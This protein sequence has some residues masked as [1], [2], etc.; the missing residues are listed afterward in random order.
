MTDIM[1]DHSSLIQSCTNKFLASSSSNILLSQGVNDGFY[2]TITDLPAQYPHQCYEIPCSENASVGLVLG[3][4]TY[5]LTPI[6]CFQRVEF[7]FLAMEQFINNSCKNTFLTSGKRTS[8]C[9]FRLV[10]GRGWGQGPSHS[11]SFESL[12]T[13]IPDLNVYLPALP[14]DSDYIFNTFP[15]TIYPT[16]SIEHRWC[17]YSKPHPIKPTSSDPYFVLSHNQPL[18][19]IVSSSYS[20]LL[21]LHVARILLKYSIC[22]DV[23]NYF[24]HS[25][26]SRSVIYDSL[27]RTKRLIVVDVSD[28]RNSLSS[29][30]ISDAFMDGTVLDAPPIALSSKSNYSPSSPRLV[31]SHYLTVLDIATSV[32]DSLGDIVLPDLRSSIL[33]HCLSV[34]KSQS[35]DQP[36]AEFN[37]PF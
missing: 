31:G 1:R 23:V 14:G 25:S 6:L 24:C 2:G 16:V 9:L 28:S 37:G 21:S 26:S 13:S 22:V 30:L 12:F 32:L 36:T 4:A 19:T 29:L 20:L 35:I 5:G 3:A 27:S 7:A 34:S 11:Q 10:I 33:N 8:P 15:T 18:I 17:H